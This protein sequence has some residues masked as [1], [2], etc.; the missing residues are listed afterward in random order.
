MCWFSHLS[1]KQAFRLVW[2]CFFCCQVVF[3]SLL[4]RFGVNDPSKC[5]EKCLTFSRGCR[6]K[7]ICNLPSLNLLGQQSL[8]RN[9]DVGFFV[10]QVLDFSFWPVGA[11]KTRKQKKNSMLILTS[12][13]SWVAVYRAFTMFFSLTTLA[14]SEPMLSG[15][16]SPSFYRSEPRW[17]RYLI[18]RFVENSWRI[19]VGLRGDV[20]LRHL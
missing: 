6:T 18:V 8:L 19:N 16:F 15:V 12:S 5:Q 3:G 14:S 4:Q 17:N 1:N 13:C 9:S 11:S 10:C 20:N 2:R 7:L